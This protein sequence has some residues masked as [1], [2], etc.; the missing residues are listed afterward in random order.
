MVH[1]SPETTRRHSSTRSPSAERPRGGPIDPRP[2]EGHRRLDRRSWG[3]GVSARATDAP[4]IFMIS[5]AS[6]FAR[7]IV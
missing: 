6:Y 2:T 7:A 1:R 5:G 4:E 3:Q